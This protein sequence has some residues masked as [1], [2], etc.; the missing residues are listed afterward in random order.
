MKIYGSAAA[1]TQDI[2]KKGLTGEWG[3]GDFDWVF[4]SNKQSEGE[5]GLFKFVSVSEIG[6]T[7]TLGK[8]V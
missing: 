3:S 5:E 2:P 1:Q 4:Q 6:G 7:G 8:L